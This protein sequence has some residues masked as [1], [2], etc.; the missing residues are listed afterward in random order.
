[1]QHPVAYYQNKI[2]FYHYTGTFLH[3]P[4]DVISP[5]SM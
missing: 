5:L 1:M 2:P 4:V 3:Q